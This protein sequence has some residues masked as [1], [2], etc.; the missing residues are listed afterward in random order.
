MGNRFHGLLLSIAL[1]LMFFTSW[2]D[3]GGILALAATAA[4]KVGGVTAFSPGSP[5]KTAT[6]QNN[7]DNAMAATSQ[8]G[9]GAVSIVVVRGQPVLT[10]GGFYVCEVDKVTAQAN[11]TTQLLLA[12][13]WADGL[14]AALRT[15]AHAISH[16]NSFA[17]KAAPR[18]GTAT[19][20]AGSFSYY[21]HGRLIY[22]PKG[23]TIPIVLTNGVSSENARPGDPIEGRVAEDISL[24]DTSIPA[25][26]VVL[27]QVTQSRAGGRMAKAGVL[28]FRFNQIRTPDGTITPIDAHVLQGSTKYPALANGDD[29]Y[30]GETTSSRVKK[31]AIDT[32]IGAGVGTL[33]GAAI[34]AIASH[35]YGT[36]RGAIAGLVA[37]S[38]IG[39]GGSLLLRKGHDVNMNSGEVLRLQLDA[40]AQIIA[41]E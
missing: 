5:Q 16:A 28:G 31:I 9:P 30:K 34:G 29:L 10:Y 37:G 15:P 20:Q 12:H 35:G 1:I 17:G 8:Q 7:L 22:V 4:V 3:V 11:K 19:T 41:K 40:P 18:V 32:G 26:S 39:G 21:R 36:G 38:A 24:G 14:K 25:N 27:G 23:M 6:I 33:A 2:P 13:R